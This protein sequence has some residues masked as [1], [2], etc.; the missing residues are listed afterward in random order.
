MLAR[1]N[2]IEKSYFLQNSQI[3]EIEK[4]T[5]SNSVYITQE[6]LNLVNK[7]VEEGYEVFNK[8]NSTLIEWLEQCKKDKELIISDAVKLGMKKYYRIK[9]GKDNCFEEIV[10]DYKY[11]MIVEE[12]TQELGNFYQKLV[13]SYCAMSIFVDKED[14]K[15]YETGAFIAGG[16]IGA[17]ATALLIAL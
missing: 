2:K 13:D 10:L 17:I 6:M 11:Q 4:E 7:K 12:K 1:K 15:H 5:L 9:T 3:K 8:D 14:A 16:V